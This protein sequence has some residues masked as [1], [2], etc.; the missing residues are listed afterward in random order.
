MARDDIATTD[1]QVVVLAIRRYLY[2]PAVLAAGLQQPLAALVQYVAST[3][4]RIES[5]ERQLR[6]VRARG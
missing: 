1:A 3:E 6:E 2:H 4:H 5:L